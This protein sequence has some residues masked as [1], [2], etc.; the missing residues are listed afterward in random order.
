M[1]RRHHYDVIEP[2]DV[3]GDVT[4]RLPMASSYRLPI[5]KNPISVTVSEIFGLKWYDFM[6]SLLTSLWMYQLSV[7]IFWTHDTGDHYVKRSSNSEQKSRRR[8]IL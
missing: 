1:L 8:S 7:W 4:T 5:G 3:I 6:T 2:S